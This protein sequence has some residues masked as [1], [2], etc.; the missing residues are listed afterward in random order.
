MNKIYLNILGT[1]NFD[2]EDLSILQDAVKELRP[3]YGTI[4]Y[5]PVIELER[6]IRAELQK[7]ERSKYVWGEF[8]SYWSGY[9]SSQRK[10]VGKHYRK[11]QKDI[12]QKM[13]KYFSH[14]FSDDTTNDWNIKIVS[15]K[16]KDEGSYEQQ[17]DEFLAK[18]ESNKESEE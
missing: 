17:I 13:P 5:E 4:L 14:K 15:V 1:K 9:T 8:I 2:T 3:Q 18:Q 10:I 11:I 6:K 7:R 16:G 12:A